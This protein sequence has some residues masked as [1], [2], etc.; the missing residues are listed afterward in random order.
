MLWNLH[1]PNHVHKNLPLNPSWAIWVQSTPLVVMSVSYMLIS[2][3]YASK[4][5]ISVWVSDRFCIHFSCSAM[6]TGFSVPHP[7]QFSEACKLWSSS[8]CNFFHPLP[9]VFQTLSPRTFVLSHLQTVFFS[10]LLN[11]VPQSCK[12]TEETII[13]VSA[14]AC[15]NWT[16]SSICGFILLVILS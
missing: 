14:Q 4:L 7:C 16:L 13:L 1:V 11:Q 15:W 9:H 12:T 3:N 2:S 10:S 6:Y 8:S 5:P